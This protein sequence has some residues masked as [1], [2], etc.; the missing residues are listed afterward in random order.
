MRSDKI[1][2]IR[3]IGAN[4]TLT[5][6]VGLQSLVADSE[7]QLTVDILLSGPNGRALGATVLPMSKSSYISTAVI[8]SFDRHDSGAYICAAT[9][10]SA[11]PFLTESSTLIE[12]LTLISGNDVV[13]YH[14][15]QRGSE[16]IVNNIVASTIGY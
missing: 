12:E 8:Y 5:C 9:L 6:I 7:I 2:P 3:P 10:A 15:D 11:S 16:G 13:C 1:N 14:I 4:V